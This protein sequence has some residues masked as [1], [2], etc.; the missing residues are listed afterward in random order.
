MRKLLLAGLLG[1]TALFGAGYAFADDELA[2][3]QNDPKQWVMP[4]GNFSSTAFSELKQITAANV[5]KL[6]PA[7]TFSTGV[8]RGHE[9]ATPGITTRIAI[10]RT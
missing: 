1:A 2:K 7:W 3:L 4:R 10:P 9:G 5:H 8:L 6:S